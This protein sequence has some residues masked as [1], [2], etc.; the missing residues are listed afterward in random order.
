MK[1]DRNLRRTV[2]GSITTAANDAEQ[3]KSDVVPYNHDFS[4]TENHAILCVWPLR[5]D[6]AK[7]ADSDRGAM[8][9]MK[10]MGDEGVKT[11]IYVWNIKNANNDNDNLPTSPI[12]SFEAPPM[13]AYHHINA[14]ESKDIHGNGQLIVDVSGYQRPD[15]VNSEFA[16]ALIHNMIDPTLRKKQVRDARY[17]RYTLPLSSRSVLTINPTPLPAQSIL[18]ARYTAELCTINPLHRGKRYR[19]SYGFTAFGGT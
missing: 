11:K 18:G 2:V 19:Y 16:F 4:L 3:G 12:A 1:T 9:D 15:I 7:G 6:L 10:W 17:Y 8:R 14:Y 5:M 13:F